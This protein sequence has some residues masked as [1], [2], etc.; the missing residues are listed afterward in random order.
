M[1]AFYTREGDDGTTGLLGEGRVPKYDLQPQAYGTV[2]ECSAA[3]G[4]A[5]SL[6]RSEE[7]KRVLRSVQRDLYHIMAELAATQ[8]T[9]E[10]FRTVGSGSVRWLEEQ[11]ET[12][13]S[14]VDVPEDFVISGDS[15]SGAALDLARTIV[16]RAERLVARLL[17][18]QVLSNPDVLRYMNRL[19]SLCFVLV[20]WEDHVSGV[21]GP[22]LAKSEDA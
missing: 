8:E 10:R 22:Q 5:R 4:L 12:F 19:S 20:L 18:D 14:E 21:S 7:T 16:R 11:V 6:A 9:A 17:H 3:L 2:D 13:S 15:P 1:A